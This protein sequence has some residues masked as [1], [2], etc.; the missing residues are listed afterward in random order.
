MR[1]FRAGLLLF[2]A[3]L[4]V[5]CLREPPDR[6]P[7]VQGPLIL[8]VLAAPAL[9]FA[10]RR[11]HRG[12][13]ISLLVLQVI[14]YLWYETGVSI[15]TNIRIDLPLIFGAIGLGAWLAFRSTGTTGG[16]DLP[17]PWKDLHRP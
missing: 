12:L 3:T 9:S 5:S 4:L 7:K 15:Q 10:I 11:R 6:T 16:R 8:F 2:L 13:Q 1:R 14:A 17:D